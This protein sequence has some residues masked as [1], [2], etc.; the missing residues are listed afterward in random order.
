MSDISAKWGKSVAGRGFAQIPNYLLLINRFIDEDSRLPPIEVLILIQLVGT[1]WKKEEKPFPSMRTL[2]V[3]CGVS[4]RQMQRSINSL[5]KKGLLLKTK[6]RTR[7]IIASN[8][9]DMQ[10]LVDTL[11]E[12]SKVF[13]NEYP[14][15]DA[16]LNLTSLVAGQ[17]HTNEQ[18]EEEEED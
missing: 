11:R 7:G 18:D 12:I 14:R 8:S 9:Y 5:V 10:P 16:K 2:A 4:E 17:S 15:R 1:W 13:P 6:R 3:R